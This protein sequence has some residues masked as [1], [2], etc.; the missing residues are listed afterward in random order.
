MIPTSTPVLD[1]TE[2]TQKQTENQLSDQF[3]AFDGP[4]ERTIHAILTFSKNLE[5]RKSDLIDTIELIKS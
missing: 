4:S 5:V 2:N 1:L 3:P